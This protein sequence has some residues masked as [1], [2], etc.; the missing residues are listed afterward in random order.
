MR[1]SARPQISVF[2]IILPQGNLFES[3]SR[4]H[5][6]GLFFRMG[7]IHVAGTVINRGNNK[8]ELRIS[9]G[10]DAN[11]KQIRKTKRVTATSMRA[12]KK[13]LDEFYLEITR[14]PR[15]TGEKI[16]FKDFVAIWDT[17]HNSKKSI[18][19]RITQMSLL[20]GRIMKEF[21]DLRLCDITGEHISRFVDKLRYEVISTK[22][23]M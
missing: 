18:S 16:L 19:T 17:R 13:A 12:A 20:D 14:T 23:V 22:A 7:M 4:I 21:Q 10:Y 6:N 3:G 11:G 1:K 9:M 2:P 8:W 15:G 5:K